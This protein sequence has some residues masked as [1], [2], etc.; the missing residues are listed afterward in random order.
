M[1]LAIQT[2]LLYLHDLLGRHKFNA[3]ADLI[4]GFRRR[5]CKFLANEKRLKFCAIRE[6]IAVVPMKFHSLKRSSKIQDENK[7]VLK[8]HSIIG[9]LFFNERGSLYYSSRSFSNFSLHLSIVSSFKFNKVRVF[10]Q[11]WNN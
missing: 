4:H 7:R 6:H 9:T 8:S 3:A 5:V 11:R 2:Q 1:Q 10:R